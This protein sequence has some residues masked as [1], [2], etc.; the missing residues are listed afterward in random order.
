MVV[1]RIAQ[2][3]TPLA[4]I[5][6]ALAACAALLV[7]PAAGRRPSQVPVPVALAWPQAKR[8]AVAADLPDGTAY[9]PGL[10]LDA[11]T[12]VGSAPTRDGKSQ[13]LVVLGANGSVREIRRLPQRSFPSFSAITAAGDM[14]VWVEQTNRGPTQLWAAS[15]RHGRPRLLTAGVGDIQFNK[16][17]YDLVVAAGRVYWV[18]S[19]RAGMT[20]IRSVALSGG[21]VADR[22]EP[23][24]WKLSAWPWLV[25]G[26]T[27]TAGATRLRNMLTGRD[28]AVAPT[29]RGTAR[30]GPVWCRVTSLDSEGTSIDLMHTDGTGRERIGDTTMAAV[31]TDPAPLGRFEIMGK[32]DTNTELTNHVQLIA[33]EIAT[34]RL[35]VI[36]PDA[37]DVT[38]S[39][40]VLWWSTGNDDSFV[41]HALDLRTV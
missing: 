32:I 28:Q 2:R 20:V 30:C 41:R 35:V 9:E 31:L 23:G 37:F 40:G 26:V 12:S 5:G 29:T 1:S 18:A 13:R 19:G 14:L 24:N 34:R 33:Y 16:S 25:N 36:S 10:F 8:A 22:P 21:P 4:G 11:G 38:Y 15:L 7:L 39:A 3:L 6:V 27:E 17:E